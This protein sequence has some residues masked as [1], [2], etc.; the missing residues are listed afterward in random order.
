MAEL[1]ARPLAD[2]IDD[3]GLDRVIERL[4]D[5][6]HLL[7]ESTAALLQGAPLPVD[8]VEIAL[9]WRDSGRF[10]AWLEAAYGQ[11]WNARW[12]EFGGLPPRLAGGAGRAGS[13]G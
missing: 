2:L 1:A 10:T 6:P 8:G 5:L 9:R 12:E 13:A 7:T 4:G 11:R 3:L